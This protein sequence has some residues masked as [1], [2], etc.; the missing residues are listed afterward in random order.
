MNHLRTPGRAVA[1]ACCL[2]GIGIFASI[3]TSA[4]R[5]SASMAGEAAPRS[6]K[7]L[8]SLTLENTT[9][10]SAL[11]VATGQFTPPGR[12]G[13]SDP[14]LFSSL[15]SFC[16]VEAVLRPTGDSEIGVEVWLPA[17]GW[18]GKFQAVGN[19]GWSGSISYPALARAVARGY[20]AASTDT[21]H[22]G[23]RAAFALGSPE[24]LIDF[25]WRGVHLTAVRG[26]AIVDGFYG[27]APKFSYWNGCS[28][29]GRQG[30]K[31]AQRFPED[32]DGIV[33]GAPANNWV[34]QKV[35]HI[36]VQ[37]Q[38]NRDATTK[39]PAS[40]YRA[41]HKA[42]LDACDQLDGVRD[43]V[44]EDPRKC[45]FDP[46]VLTCKGADG[47][48]CLTSTEVAT[49]K[50]LYAPV[51]DPKTK[52]EIF[53]GL[54]PGTELSWET[55]AGPE[56]RATQ[57]D[58]LTYVVFKNPKWDYKTFD[59]ERDL[60]LALKIDA[61]GSTTAATDADL[62]PFV[63][64]G[65]KLLLYHGWADPNIMAMN[66]VNYYGAVVK[67]IGGKAAA[68]QS[69]RLFMVPGMGHCSGGDG[70][71]TFDAIGALERWVERKQP[72]ARIE[73]SRVRNGVVERTRPLCAYPQVARYAGQGSTDEAR[74][75][76]CAE[77]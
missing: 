59:V 51:V 7:A 33:A 29:G 76:V 67:A 69:V 21:G 63:R 11:P 66:T 9:I 52:V 14:A 65:G 8:K 32:F 74:N 30:L 46:A 49:A 41:L 36:V 45:S 28:S 58:L 54:Q 12:E 48:E 39:I 35:A 16:R 44:L 47:P 24:K 2:A 70:T 18:N 23:D 38:V 40:K 19:G 27:S 4:H 72:P 71:D 64:R 55:P 57:I 13:R 77:R 73:A 60:P 62:S 31:E 37:Q 26:K 42:V 3:G 68:D 15:P 25:A 75:F 17:E 56:P 61:T 50:M 22:K 10:V 20:A 5:A 6:C 53:P 43:G 34:K 1:A